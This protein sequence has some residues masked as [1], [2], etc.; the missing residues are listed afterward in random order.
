MFGKLTQLFNGLSPEII[1]ES[2][3]FTLTIG[4]NNI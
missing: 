1:E 3:I 2:E 4:E